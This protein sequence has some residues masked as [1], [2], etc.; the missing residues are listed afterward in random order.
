MAM[1][2]WERVQ[3]MS[4]AELQA[5]TCEILGIAEDEAPNFINDFG[6]AWGLLVEQRKKEDGMY[7]VASI[8]AYIV[9]KDKP[10]ISYSEC[11]IKD[12][13]YIL[14]K[15]DAELVLRGF[16]LDSPRSKGT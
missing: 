4:K 10:Y 13:A 15:L 8:I 1:T 2:E 14:R 9:F 5:N 3:A 16:I 7:L 11:D 12:L 6:A